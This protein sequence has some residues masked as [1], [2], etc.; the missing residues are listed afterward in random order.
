MKSRTRKVIVLKPWRAI[1]RR[2][3]IKILQI[4]KQEGSGLWER[5]E[6]ISC[7][8]LQKEGWSVCKP[9]GKEDDQI[10]S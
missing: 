2:E 3:Y 7:G 4:C 1:I 9:S 8:S 5:G 10:V 6:G